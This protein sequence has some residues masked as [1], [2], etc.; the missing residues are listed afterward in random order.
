MI[1]FGE[2]TKF[3][4]RR[5][6]S[7]VVIRKL[8]VHQF[9][10]LAGKSFD[11]LAGSSAWPAAEVL[12]SFYTQRHLRPQRQTC[13]VESTV[14]QFLRLFGL[15]LSGILC[16]EILY[17]AEFAFKSILVG[18]RNI[19]ARVVGVQGLRQVFKVSL[20]TFQFDFLLSIVT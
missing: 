10:P 20:N 11:A 5:T 17:A 19:L 6:R 1:V 4:G 16:L 13:D 8:L 18:Q 15:S 7:S 3:K 2:L 14:I 9:L 12:T